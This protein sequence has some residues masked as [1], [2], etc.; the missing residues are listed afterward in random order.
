MCGISNILSEKF[1]EFFHGFIWEFLGIWFTRMKARELDRLYAYFQGANC[2]FQGVYLQ[3]WP[4][5]VING[6]IA[7]SCEWSYGPL[8]ITG[9]GPPC[10]W[11]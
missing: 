10:R 1:W 4:L 2:S 5:V 7:H 9:K 3:G 8:L 11:W 6:V